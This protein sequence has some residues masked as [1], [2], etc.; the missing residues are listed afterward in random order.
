[1]KQA[2]LRKLPEALEKQMRAKEMTPKELAQKSKISY[3]SLMPI[4]SGNRECSISKLVALSDALDCNPDDLLDGLF[5]SKSSSL[6]SVKTKEPKFLLVF[7]S[8][9]RVTYCI[10]YDVE[11][12]NT[13]ET[14]MQFPL[15]CGDEADFFLDNVLS[16]LDKLSRDLHKTVNPREV[17][18]FASVQQYGRKANRGKI[19]DKGDR[20]FLK[21]Y[22]ESDA[23]TN[24]DAFI[25]NN[26]GICVTINTGNIITYSI[27]G[28]KSIVPLQGYGFPISDTAG[29]Y[30]IGCEAIRHAINVK[31]QR[32]PASLISDRLLALYNDDV[33]YLCAST[34][35]AP[36]AVYLKA[37]SIVKEFILHESKAHEIVKRS[38][39]LLFADIQ[40]IDKKTKSKMPIFVTGE[41]AYLY[42]GFFPKDRLISVDERQSVVLLKH[43]L[44]KLK[45]LIKNHTT[46]GINAGR[47]LPFA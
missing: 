32:E 24:H 17:A 42:E 44:A 4:L 27:D 11:E 9:I 5:I 29:N 15:R 33:N 7:I 20:F 36:T 31:E 8:I 25:G 38:F 26:N 2:I 10:L 30:W 37:S 18:I 12:N 40:M 14:V 34:M 3:S 16:T 41:L 35:E 23:V 22:L 21:F 46:G 28:G 45:G 19:Q 39:D 13:V 1:M 43:G 6:K 47:S